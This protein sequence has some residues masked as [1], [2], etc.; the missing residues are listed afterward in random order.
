MANCSYVPHPPVY[1]HLLISTYL[2]LHF[3]LA[4]LLGFTLGNRTK[5]FLSSMLTRLTKYVYLCL[6]VKLC[7]RVALCAV[8]T[9]LANSLEL[10][11]R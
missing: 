8:W 1:L 6:L 11:S 10:L 7:Y 2:I 4:R 3:M 9:G 5:Y